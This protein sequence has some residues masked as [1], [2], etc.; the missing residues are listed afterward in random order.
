MFRF[1]IQIIVTLRFSSETYSFLIHDLPL[2]YIPV[3]Y[4]VPL[5]RTVGMSRGHDGVV[6]QDERP[7]FAIILS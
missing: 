3:I 5:S 4:Y 7:T 2:I 1:H 6:R